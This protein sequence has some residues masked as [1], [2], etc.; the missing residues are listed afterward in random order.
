M[1]FFGNWLNFVYIVCIYK[2]A[3]SEKLKIIFGSILILISR[4]TGINKYILR[5]LTNNIRINLVF[6]IKNEEEESV[7]NEYTIVEIVVQNGHI[8]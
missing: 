3:I 7:S 4:L 5:N 6:N 2:G 8:C 1:F